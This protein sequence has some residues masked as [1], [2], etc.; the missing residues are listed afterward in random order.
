MIKMAKLIHPASEKTILLEDNLFYLPAAAT[1][2]ASTHDCELRPA[3]A[4]NDTTND[5]LFIIPASHSKL[6]SLADIRFKCDL[7]VIPSDGSVFD[8]KKT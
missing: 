8:D 1:E 2:R 5:Y 7:V 4:I 6:I 3:Q